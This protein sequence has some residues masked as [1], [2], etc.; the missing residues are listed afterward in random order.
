MVTIE[1][2]WDRREGRVFGGE[3]TVSEVNYVNMVMS[4]ITTG[5]MG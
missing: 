5:V 2:C 3:D 4:G 1:G